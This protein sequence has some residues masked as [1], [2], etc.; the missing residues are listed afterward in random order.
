MGQVTQITDYDTIIDNLR[1][2]FFDKSNLVEGISKGDNPQYIELEQLYFNLR[3]RRLLDTAEGV[4]LDILGEILNLDR[5]GRDDASYRTLLKLK[6]DINTSFATPEILIKSVKLL[7]GA[8]VVNYIPDYPAG[9]EIEQN[10][11]GGLFVLNNLIAIDTNN[12]VTISGDNLTTREND[13]I[14]QDLIDAVVP[15]GVSVTITNI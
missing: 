4:Q 12:L 15:A 11:A 13:T 6:V 10:G 5:F 8:T 1:I 7:Y 2:Q 9:V 3:D 14:A